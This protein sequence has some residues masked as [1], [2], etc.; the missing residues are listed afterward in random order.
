MTN[1][2]LVDSNVFIK[3][4]RHRID[5]IDTLGKWAGNRNLAICGMIRVEVLRGIRFPAGYRRI[6]GFMD[7]MVNIRTSEN[8]W[9]EATELAWSLDRKGEV[10]PVTDIIIAASAMSINAAV[11]T[12]DKHFH[13]IEGLEVIAPPAEWLS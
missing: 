9:I 10:I 5:P 7:T 6:S 2:V 11:L 3:L 4:L 8:L 12:S 1:D 13:G